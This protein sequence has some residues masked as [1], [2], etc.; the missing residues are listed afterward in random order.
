M[1]GGGS[2][3]PPP[4]DA[5]LLSKTLTHP[6]KCPTPH[7][8]EEVGGVWTP[9]HQEFPK[10]PARVGQA[11]ST[12]LVLA[13]FT[14]SHSQNV[15]PDM[16]IATS[17]GG[18]GGGAQMPSSWITMQQS[19]ADGPQQFMTVIRYGLPCLLGSTAQHSTAQH[20]TAQH[21]TAQH[22]TQHNTAQ[23]ST[24]QHSTAQHSTAQQMVRLCCTVRTRPTSIGV[25][26]C[27]SSS[28]PDQCPNAEGQG[29]GCRPA[30]LHNGGI[31]HGAARLA[32]VAVQGVIRG[33]SI[34]NCCHG[35]S[36]GSRERGIRG[37]VD[38]GPV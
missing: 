38:E 31:G 8:G 24:A 32:H 37:D 29:C 16:G 7:G 30:R 6:P 14:W 5:E 9:T 13:G 27:P 21:S 19:I 11:P 2:D 23:H 28:H 25:A 1:G 4:G 3:P 17:T 10:Y 15:T 35:G 12:S 18:G 22:S 36:G 26:T 34:V 20:S 33:Q